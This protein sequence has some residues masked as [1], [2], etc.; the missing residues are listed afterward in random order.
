MDNDAARATEPGHGPNR[1]DNREHIPNITEPLVGGT[2]DTLDPKEDE[3]TGLE[4]ID[5]ERHQELT[6]PKTA[7]IQIQPVF[8]YSKPPSQ[9]LQ[10]SPT[11]PPPPLP[12]PAVSN[13]QNKALSA[14]L[15][16]Q[17]KLTSVVVDSTQSSPDDTSDGSYSSSEGFST[18]TRSSASTTR[19]TTATDWPPPSLTPIITASA[20]APPSGARKEIGFPPPADP[21]LTLMGLLPSTTPTSPISSSYVYS[22]PD[23][24]AAA[25]HDKGNVHPKVEMALLALGSVGASIIIASWKPHFPQNTS[26]DKPKLFV[27]NA[28]AH[29]P[30]L[31]DRV[32]NRQHRWTDLDR[33]DLG[34]SS[35]KANVAQSLATPQPP[36]TGVA[37]QTDFVRQS[38]RTEGPPNGASVHMQKISI[39]SI[40]SSTRNTLLPEAQFRNGRLSNVSS[41]SS[42]FGDGHFIMDSLNSSANLASNTA[43]ETPIKAPWPVAR[44]ESVGTLSQRRDTVYTEASEDMRP[45]FRTVNSWVRQQ[46][47]RMKRV[48][49]LNEATDAPPVPSLP[50]EQDFGLMMPD[51]EEPR[52]A[53]SVIIGYGVAR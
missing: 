13:P 22:T 41:L 34:P 20:P 25:K 36:L 15:H 16:Y 18:L 40:Q 31:K 43:S 28:L 46:M 10:A 50:P 48:H 49:E 5:D 52:R 17:P 21:V 37:V 9:H 12:P 23:P 14:D 32:A 4:D 44:R 30:V 27:T 42:G 8:T 7:P 35:E 38:M 19:P 39:S 1:L 33:A 24:N 26:R 2:V 53:D 29:I 45:R 51:G 6:D 11:P 47:G 3:Q